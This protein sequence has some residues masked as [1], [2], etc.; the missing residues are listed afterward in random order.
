MNIRDD[1]A[2]HCKTMKAC[3]IP[4]NLQSPHEVYFSNLNADSDSSLDSSSVVSEEDDGEGIVDCIKKSS[5][6][7]K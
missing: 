4:G 2:E 5:N 1:E 7:A 6:G 3:Q